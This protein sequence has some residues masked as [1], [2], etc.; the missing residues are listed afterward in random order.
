MATKY[1]GLFIW[2]TDVSE[3]RSGASS[4]GSPGQSIDHVVC[5]RGP[6]R[7]RMQTSRGGGSRWQRPQ[8]DSCER[9]GQ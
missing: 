5:C 4:A 9:T 3:P 2:K 8:H 7:G 1:E 6:S